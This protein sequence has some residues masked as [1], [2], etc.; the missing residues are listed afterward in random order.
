MGNTI[1]AE[2]AKGQGG[3]CIFVWDVTYFC[4]GELEGA[5]VTG[6]PGAG[7]AGCV[8]AGV[9]LTPCST[10]F[11]PPCLMAL[12]ERVTEVSMKSTAEIVVAF[13]SAVAAPRGPNAAWLP[14]PPKAAEMSPA[15]PL[16]SSTTTIKKRQTITWT[17]VTR[18]MSIE[19]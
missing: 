11:G 2:P 17:I 9:V 16:C 8:L 15:L 3:D 12:M 14:C 4:V 1:T 7:T 10:E 13:D 19:I 18:M 6:V 5:G